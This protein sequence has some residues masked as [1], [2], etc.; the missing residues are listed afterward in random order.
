MECDPPLQNRRA[1]VTG[2]TRGI[3]LAVARKLASLG[4]EVVVSGRSDTKPTSV[5]FRYLPA[6]FSVPAQLDA[7]CSAVEAESPDIVVNNAGINRVAPFEQVTTRDFLDVLSVNLVAPFQVC[8]A[9]V[10][11][12]KRRGW[13]RIVNCAS[14]FGVVS[15]EFRAAYSASKFGL[16]GMTAALAAEVVRYGI[17]ANCVSPGFIDTDLTRTI[18][19]ETG[20]ATLTSAVPARRLGT[21]DEIAELVAW[22]AGPRNSFVSGQ[23]YVI[24]GGFTRV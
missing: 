13:G 2:G 1:L 5:A 23:N 12:M 19:G 11:A 10:P 16:D 17:L 24:D 15:K 18:L 20:I 22:L 3:G 14:I 7:F 6:D 21:P 4:A 9:A 8:R